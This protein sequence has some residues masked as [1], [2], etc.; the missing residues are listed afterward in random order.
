MLSTLTYAMDVA[1]ARCR[2]IHLL[3]LALQP[4]AAV[5]RR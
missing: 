3:P 2:H 4:A 5:Y 1:E